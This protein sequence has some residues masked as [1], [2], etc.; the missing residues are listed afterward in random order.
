[1]ATGLVTALDKQGV[2]VEI[3]PRR[4]DVDVSD[5]RG[6]VKGVYVVVNG[7]GDEIIPMEGPGDGWLG[8]RI[9][10]AVSDIKTPELEQ[11]V[12]AI[13]ADAAD[14]PAIY[15]EFKNAEARPKKPIRRN[16]FR[17]PR[18]RRF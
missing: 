11:E 3:L 6:T 18:S 1:M 15:S 9:A 12:L 13:L 4:I 7:I 16:E 14:N 10:D 5:D 2:K 8:P 17:A